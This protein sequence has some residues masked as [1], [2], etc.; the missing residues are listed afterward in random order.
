MK[1]NNFRIVAL[2]DSITQGFP[3]GENF[4]WATIVAQ[5]YNVT[6]INKG[7]CGDYTS[8]MALRFKR[9]V[10][11]ENPLAVIVL[12]GYNDAFS[13]IPAIKVARNFTEIWSLAEENSIQPVF[14][15]PTPV[16]ISSVEELLSEYRIWIKEFATANKIPLIDFYKTFIDLQ[17]KTI[18]PGVTTDGAHPTIKGYKLM[19]TAVN[20]ESNLSNINLN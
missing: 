14:A 5:K 10:I 16:S 9:D 3:Y 17:K 6:I 2:G 4:S 12:G 19:A 15:L 18:I 8:G 7:I 11:A 13:A 20:I 1:D